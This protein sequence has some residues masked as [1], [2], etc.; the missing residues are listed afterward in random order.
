MEEPATENEGENGQDGLA[1]L[2]SPRSIVIVGATPNLAR[3]G[4]IPLASLLAHG[5]PRERILL[6]NPKYGEIEGIR[7]YPDIAAL[8]VVPDLAVIAVPARA[9]IDSLR[10]LDAIGVRAAVLFAAG[11]GEDPTPE[12]QALER[13]LRAFLSGTSMRIAGPNT[14]GIANIATGMSASFLTT[15][16]EDLPKGGLA[17]IGQSG[18]TV[19]MM[20]SDARDYG[21]GMSYFV[22][23]G[24]ESDLTFAD[25]LAH[26]LRDGGTKA[27][28]GYCEEV[29][30]GA[31]FANAAV[32]LREAGKPLFL[33]KV[34]RSARAREAAF[35][36]TGAL[37]G[38]AVLQIAALRQLGAAVCRDPTEVMDMARLWATG[39]RVA[40]GGVAIVSLSGAGCA[41]L[42]DLF[43]DAGVAIP[44]LDPATQAALRAVIPSFGM[45]SNPVDLTGNVINDMSALQAVMEALL[46][47]PGT[48]CIVL[49]IMGSLLDR[50]ADA[51]LAARRASD[52]LIVVIDPSHATRAPELRAAGVE[53]F[54]DCLRTATSLATYLDWC[55]GPR[56]SSWRPQA[57]PRA[58]APEWVLAKT[59]RATL[60][61]AEARALLDGAGVDFVSEAVVT[62]PDGAASAADAIGYP[63]ALKI[64]DDA[65]PHKSDVG[66]VA[67]GLHTAGAVRQA[68]REIAESVATRCGRTAG[69]MVVQKMVSGPELL[70]GLTRDPVF[71][72]ALTVGLGGIL[73]EIFGDTASAILPVDREMA[74]AMLAKLRFAAVFAGA[75]GQ[76]PVDVDAVAAM[77]ARLGAFFAARPWLAEIEL[78]P[79]VLTADGPRAVDAIARLRHVPADVASGPDAG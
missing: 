59:G 37:T 23:S 51:L 46:R 20:V 77:L 67:L 66:G 62:G 56:V 55:T 44:T 38:N 4:G 17:L 8:P 45:V 15:L 16:A 3:I 49:Y 2:F 52:K 34:G 7:C 26:F 73:T 21:L 72:A 24:N 14:M 71:G 76:P 35:S 57:A 48:D 18:N 69:R 40:R 13:D 10:K 70:V 12:G 25:Y 47:D 79:V 32:R 28:L 19:S 50:A 5:F 54:E 65:I 31:R 42:S 74:K 61:A 60:D 27:V 36:H 63:V 29:R 64:L 78:N 30:D 75:R 1:P 9:T 53:V 43:A 22:S 39:A 68:W 58:A 33:A 41:F 11:F 6:V